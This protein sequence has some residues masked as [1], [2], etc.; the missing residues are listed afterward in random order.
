MSSENH[1]KPY[2]RAISR[3]KRPW[4]SKLG[5]LGY[6]LVYFLGGIPEDL[7]TST[8]HEISLFKKIVITPGQNI[9]FFQKK[10]SKKYRY[11]SLIL[12]RTQTQCLEHWQGLIMIFLR[13]F[14]WIR[15]PKGVVNA[16]I[17][18]FWLNW[19]I[20]Y[21]GFETLLCLTSTVRQV[22]WAKCVFSSSKSC[23]FWWF[24]RKCL[25]GENITINQTC[26]V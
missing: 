9:T 5:T 24:S 22:V 17:C 18:Q 23:I 15:Y 4:I 26:F 12:I 21:W 25:I 19:N 8:L 13:L 2:F 6:T 14:L 10:N 7:T 16:N 20:Y 11:F 3:P 1:P